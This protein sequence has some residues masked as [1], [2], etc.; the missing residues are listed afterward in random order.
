MRPGA[1]VAA[2]IEVLEAIAAHHR[3]ASLA[4]ADWGRTHRF[5]GAGDRAAIGNLVFDALRRRA[6]AAWLMGDDTPRA[7]TLG[8]LRLAWEMDTP[9][10]ERLFDG[11]RHAPGV[12]V[13]P[14]SIAV[15]LLAVVSVAPEKAR[16]P[17]CCATLSGA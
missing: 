10:I 6:S 8:T 15:T 1:R 3:P 11:S 5:A 12:H 4:L 17:G 9:A 16:T 14:I 13:G 7:L 2:A